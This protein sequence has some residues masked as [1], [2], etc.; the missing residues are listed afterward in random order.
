MLDEI[1]TGEENTEAA[2]Q[3]T[4]GVEAS[5]E[6]VSQEATSAAVGNQDESVEGL[7]A[8]TI[9]ERTKRQAVEAELEELKSGAEEYTAPVAPQAQ[10]NLFEQVATQ[11]GYD[12]DYLTPVQNGQVVEGMMHVIAAR[13]SQNEF[14]M[15]HPDYSQVVGVV[16]NGVFHA[17]PPLKR[18]YKRNP[19]IQQAINSLGGSVHTKMLAYELAISDPDYQKELKK[20]GMSAEEIKAAEAQA[21]LNAANQPLSV[22]A[23]KGSGAVDKA[24]QIRTESDEEFQARLE[25]VKSQGN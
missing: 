25:R 22:S 13:Q 8:A 11:L 19:A 17:A 3:E 5:S 2:A 6:S 21:K 1:V 14:Y 16:R 24:N 18:V 10:T 9:A 12:I 23:A 15:S 4:T 20:A 7:K